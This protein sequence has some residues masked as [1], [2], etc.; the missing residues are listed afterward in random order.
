LFIFKLD[1]VFQTRKF[2]KKM[3]QNIQLALLL[4]TLSII[5]FASKT[6]VEAATCRGGYTARPFAN[7]GFEDHANCGG[8]A[9]CYSTNQ[10]LIDPWFVTTPHKVFEIDNFIWRD[11]EGKSWSSD[12]SSD[13]PITL[14]QCIPTT[15]GNSYQV[16]FW[17]NVNPCGVARK[18]GYLNISSGAFMSYESSTGQPWKFQQLTF[19]ATQDATLIEFGSTTAGSCG[20]VIDKV[21]VTSAQCSCSNVVSSKFAFDL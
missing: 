15:P 6:V 3:I 12:L 13:A 8:A 19:T 14:G 11:Y 16:T 2:L 20:P 5:N 1:S 17:L 10:A 9:W 4:S 18:T 7:G 21:T